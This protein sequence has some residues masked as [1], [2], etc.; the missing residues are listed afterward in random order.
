MQQFIHITKIL[1]LIKLFLFFFGAFTTYTCFFR[2]LFIPLSMKLGLSGVLE[3]FIAHFETPNLINILSYCQEDLISLP[4]HL[5]A[6]LNVGTY[7]CR[8]YSF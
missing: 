6:E 8:S 1:S 4:E 7:H 3:L 5:I 2:P